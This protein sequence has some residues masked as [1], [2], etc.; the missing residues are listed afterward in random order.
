MKYIQTSKLVDAQ[1][2]EWARTRNIHVDR[3]V[4]VVVSSSKS[5]RDRKPDQN[6]R[7]TLLSPTP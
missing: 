2:L 6:S 4:E 5:V 3:R 1:K 7:I